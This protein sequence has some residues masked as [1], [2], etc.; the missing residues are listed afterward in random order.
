METLK[1]VTLFSG[2]G[3][4]ERGIENTGLFDIDVV[5]TSDIDKEAIVSYASIHCGLTP[6]L[7]NT[8]EQYP[9]REDMVKELSE[10]NIGY[11]FTKKKPYDWIKV[12]RKKDKSELNRYWLAV[13]LSK[14]FGDISKI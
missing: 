14:N 13:Q 1:V 2:I 9:S 10:K 3:C 8:Y 6:E 11:D 7:V 4:Q 12:E 5:A